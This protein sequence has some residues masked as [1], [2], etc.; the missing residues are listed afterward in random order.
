MGKFDSY[1]PPPIF[2]LEMNINHLK[3]FVETVESGSFSKAARALG[4]SQPAVS[5]HINALEK[6]LQSKLLERTGKQ[7]VLTEAGKVLFKHALTIV[8]EMERLEADMSSSAAEP[9]GKIRIAASSIPGEHILPKLL[10][11]FRQSYPFIQISVEIADTSVATRKTVQAEVDIGFTGAPAEEGVIEN[12]PLCPD[13]L[14]LITPPQ[15]P[16]AGRKSIKVEEIKGQDFIMREEGSGT[17]LRMIQ[18]FSEV[19]ISLGDLNV[20]ME[21][22][23]TNAVINAVAA[24]AGVSLVSQWAL[25]CP[26]ARG[27]IEASRIEGVN[28]SRNFYYITRKKTQPR[29]V[30][31]LVDFVERRKEGLRFPER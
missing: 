6:E 27:I 2:L 16:L 22:G 30:E 18:S 1:A 3:A 24:S 9:A 14:L 12:H 13:E 5:F 26:L 11:P 19:G 15:H 29:Q 21:L 23:S 8:R 31:A 10:G 28:L 25:D 20:V 7:L 4:I 17:R